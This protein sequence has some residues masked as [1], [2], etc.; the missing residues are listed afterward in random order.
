MSI[1]K[2]IT[3]ICS[4][5]VIS[6]ALIACRVHDVNERVSTGEIAYSLGE[7]F[8][9]EFENSNS[10]NVDESDLHFVANKLQIYSYDDVRTKFP[11]YES[12]IVISDPSIDM[13]VAVV[14]FEVFNI[15]T[16]EQK[17]PLYDFN[18][19]SGSWHN[20]VNLELYKLFNDGAGPTAILHPYETG[21]FSLT[22]VIFDKQFRSRS[23][24]EKTLNGPYDLVISSY[25]NSIKIILETIGK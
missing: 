23:L 6:A 18:L 17:V 13:H 25:P 24:M 20:A 3:C 9:A 16:S 7:E 8:G 5:I 10:N 15:S 12:E 4:I 14:D 2:R 1:N 11:E 19:Q 21:Q 22:Y